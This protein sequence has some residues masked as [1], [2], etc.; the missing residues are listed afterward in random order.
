[1]TRKSAIRLNYKEF[2]KAAIDKELDTDSKIAAEIG[3]SVTQLWR[4]RL[5]INDPRYNSPGS[6]FIAG[7]LKTF[8]GPFERFFFLESNIRGRINDSNEGGE[9]DAIV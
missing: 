3:V 8:D 4:A 6:N 9:Q 7:V 2:Q 5:P 1:V